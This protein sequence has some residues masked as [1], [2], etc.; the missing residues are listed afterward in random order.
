MIAAW[1]KVA[2]WSW[3]YQ[4][5]AVDVIFSKGKE[6]SSEREGGERRKQG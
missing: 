5:A 3:R 6:S 4:L 1:L 2:G